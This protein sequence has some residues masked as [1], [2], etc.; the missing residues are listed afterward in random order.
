MGRWPNW[1]TVSSDITIRGTDRAD[2]IGAMARAVD[3]FHDNGEKI[4]HMTRAEAAR[5]IRDE[6]TRKE[7][8]TELQSAFGSVVDAAA[9][10]DFSQRVTA[11]FPDPELN[12]L[13]S[14]VNSSVKTVDTGLAETSQCSPPSP[15]PT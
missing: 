8:M 6:E 15:M 10:G 7:M 9:E 12:A 14:S 11:D 13:A 3:V 1:P 4:A 2:E 5:I